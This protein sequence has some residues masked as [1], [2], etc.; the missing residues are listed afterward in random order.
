MLDVCIADWGRRKERGEEL[1]V[2]NLPKNH[3]RLY[4]MPMFIHTYTNISR[5]GETDRPTFY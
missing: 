3:H 4:C 1:L 2:I 5:G